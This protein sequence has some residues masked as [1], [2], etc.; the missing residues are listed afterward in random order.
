MSFT[1][2]D[3]HLN[4]SRDLQPRKESGYTREALPGAEIGSD[5]RTTRQT[6]SSGR[7]TEVPESCAAR[8]TEVFCCAFRIAQVPFAF[9]FECNRPNSKSATVCHRI[10]I[11]QIC[12]NLLNGKLV[13][14]LL[15]SITLIKCKWNLRYFNFAFC[16]LCFHERK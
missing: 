5:S 7:W 9:E 8:N 16:A 10:T 4:G 2:S 3:R 1:H 11:H 15:Q 6:G 13:T 12:R 14:K